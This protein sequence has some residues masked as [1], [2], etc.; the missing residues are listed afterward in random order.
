MNNQPYNICFSSKEKERIEKI[1]EEVGILLEDFIRLRILMPDKICFA[2]KEELLTAE[3]ATLRTLQLNLNFIS[4]HSDDSE[5]A[6]KLNPEFA[7]G[8]IRILELSNK[9][10]NDIRIKVHNAVKKYST[11]RLSDIRD[12]TEMMAI[13]LDNEEVDYSAFCD[14]KNAPLKYI[15]AK[16]LVPAEEVTDS[17]ERCLENEKKMSDLIS[18]YKDVKVNRFNIDRVYK[19]LVMLSYGAIRDYLEIVS[20]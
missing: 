11:E 3:D 18:R 1:I 8:S 12:C 15:R 13:V 5:W 16:V 2:T 4:E 9:F 14:T 6:N 10:D 20:V 19:E 17:V 7:L